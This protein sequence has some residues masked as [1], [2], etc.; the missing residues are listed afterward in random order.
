MVTVIETNTL[1]TAETSAYAIVDFSATWCGPCKMLAPVIEELSEELAG[2]V[3]FYNCDVDANN[4]LAMKYG[5]SSIPAIGI[6]KKGE[7]LDMTFG[8]KPKEDMKAFI[9]SKK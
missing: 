1:G 3:D 7:L 6:F 2:Q 4:S 5:I 9:L 8:F